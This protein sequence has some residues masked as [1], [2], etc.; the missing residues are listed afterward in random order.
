MLLSTRGTPVFAGTIK[1]GTSQANSSTLF[2]DD[3]SGDLSKWSDVNG[4]WYIDQG[5]LVGEGYD[6]S[7]YAGDT[8]WTDYALQTKINFI[9]DNAR[10][11]IRSTGISQNELIIEV[12]KDGASVNEYANTFVMY[13]IKDGVATHLANPITGHA[14][15]PIPITNP[16]VVRV[17][18]KGNQYSL[19]FNGQYVFQAYDP[20]PLTNGRIG[21]GFVWGQTTRFDDVLVTKDLLPVPPITIPPVPDFSYSPSDPSIFDTI[22]FNNNSSDPAGQYIQSILWKF[23]DGTTSIEPNPTHRYAGDKDYKVQLKITTIDGRTATTS[24]IVGV[25]T[26]DVAITGFV[27][28]LI[29]KAGKTSTILVDIENTKYPETVQ[30]DLFK[31]NPWGFELIGT[32]VLNVKVKPLYNTTEFTFRVTFT[33]EDAVYGKVTF[34]AVATVLTARDALPFD[35]EVIQFPTRVATR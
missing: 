5:E 18:V 9:G 8:Y 23:G 13:K 19:F 28:P 27:V 31:S 22:Q 2:F 1:E 4:N 32:Q 20:D 29:G 15:S 30:V 17:Q 7:I 33:N 25:H 21:L 35:N 11:S 16:I 14:Q 12:W 3:F 10:L 26:H 6:A 34:K 24:K